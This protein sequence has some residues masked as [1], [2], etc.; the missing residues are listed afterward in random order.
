[1]S[2]KNPKEQASLSG[3]QEV[4]L[5]HEEVLRHSL[6]LLQQCAPPYPLWPCLSVPALTLSLIK[7][8]EQMQVN[9]MPRS[10]FLKTVFVST[11]DLTS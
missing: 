11:G 1:M 6:H 4:K 2:K 8:K 5:L 9:R 10:Y 7:V 3:W